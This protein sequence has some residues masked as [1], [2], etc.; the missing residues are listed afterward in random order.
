M[1]FKCFQLIRVTLLW[2][3]LQEE[4]DILSG[5][6]LSYGAMIRSG[7]FGA[8]PVNSQQCIIVELLNNMKSRSYLPLLTFKFLTEGINKVSKLSVN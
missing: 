2:I 6:V 3:N 8:A 5:K 7:N 1:V 4:G